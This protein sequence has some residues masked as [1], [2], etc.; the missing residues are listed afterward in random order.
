MPITLAPSPAMVYSS[1]R[2][3]AATRFPTSSLV[4]PIAMVA[5]IAP[6]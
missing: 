2:P 5:T 6:T 3:T 4:A 1:G